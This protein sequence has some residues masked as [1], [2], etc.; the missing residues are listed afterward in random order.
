M[1][2]TSDPVMKD[3]L[4]LITGAT[5]GIGR[6]TAVRLAR[7]GA[8][9]LIVGRDPARGRAAVAGISADSGNDAVDLITADLSSQADIRRL[10]ADVLDRH[11]RL[12]VLVNNVGGLYTTRWET[13]DGIEASFAVNALGPFLLTTLLRP[14]LAPARA[15]RVVY[16]TGGMPGRLDVT[17]LQASG[18]YLGIRAYSHAK[19]AMMALAYEQA[20]RLAPAGITVNV[21]YPGA[22]NT[23]MTRAM[24]PATV[25][26]FMRVMWPLFKPVM[27]AAK[28]ERAAR[29]SVYLASDPRLAGVTGRY[30]NTRSRRARWPKDVLDDTL[31]RQVWQAA[32]RLTGLPQHDPVT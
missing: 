30:V 4:V 1:Q 15:A 29:S 8:R 23:P 7:L 19:T 6:H 17:D 2:T 27:A 10:A 31:R 9:I 5:D 28:P 24:T 20:R 32:E 25:P 16:V 18:D 21:A 12:D 26:P 11:D 14:A 22:A 3:R 13:V